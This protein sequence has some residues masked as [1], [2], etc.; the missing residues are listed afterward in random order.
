MQQDMVKKIHMKLFFGAT[1]FILLEDAVKFVLNNQKQINSLFRRERNVDELF[2]QAINIE[3]NYKKI[4][5]LG[6]V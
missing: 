1:W 4:E 3:K 5:I 2:I 6:S